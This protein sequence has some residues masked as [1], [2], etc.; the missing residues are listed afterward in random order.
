[1]PKSVI[2]APPSSPIRMFCGLTSRWTI[3]RSCAAPSARAISIAYASASGSSS[4][5]S[6]RI[7]VL[8]RLAFDVLEHDVRRPAAVLGG[9]LAG[10]DDGDDVRVVELRDGARLAAEALELVGVGG[11]LAVHQ[12]DRDRSLEHRVEGAVDGRHAAAAD[13]RSSR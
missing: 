9:L 13:L 10:V 3:S 8:E 11:D 1:M 7:S 12:L 4:R 2:F 6:R 5:P